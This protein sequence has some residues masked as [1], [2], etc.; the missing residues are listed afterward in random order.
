VST[1]QRAQSADREENHGRTILFAS[2]RDALRENAKLGKKK[3][4]CNSCSL[5]T[6]SAKALSNHMR[7][8]HDR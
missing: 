5:P 7:R 8:F 2:G 6:A 1:E 3:Y 4:K